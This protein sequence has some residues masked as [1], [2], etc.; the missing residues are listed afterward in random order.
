[1]VLH[2]P[3]LIQ[4]YLWASC[5]AEL[6]LKIDSLQNAFEEV[7]GLLIGLCFAL[8]LEEGRGHVE[9]TF[10]YCY[11]RP[12]RIQSMHPLLLRYARSLMLS[13]TKT[14]PFSSTSLKSMVQS[15]ARKL[16]S[17]L[18]YMA[19]Y[20]CESSVEA[21]APQQ[22]LTVARMTGPLLCFLR[23]GHDD[24]YRSESA[25][26]TAVAAAA[27]R[28]VQRLARVLHLGRFSWNSSVHG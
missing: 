2:Q 26:H 18:P 14:E 23:F 19:L 12:Q 16:P 6:S 4:M 22:A 3:Q 24:V 20:Y 11:G 15:R 21:C 9:L 13:G 28:P 27:T 5:L 10:T 1:M 25:I 17:A 7:P 8:L